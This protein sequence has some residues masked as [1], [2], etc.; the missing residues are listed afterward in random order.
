MKSCTGVSSE[1]AVACRYVA[2]SQ[3][4]YHATLAKVREDKISTDG[5][6]SA[7]RGKLVLPDFEAELK[8]Q[9]SRSP[10]GD[11]LRILMP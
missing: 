10:Y 6:F 3:Q 9:A 4:L 8:I 7:R 1:R 11:F 2:A 5:Q